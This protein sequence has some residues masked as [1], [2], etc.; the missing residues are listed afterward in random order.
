MEPLE[1]QYNRNRRAIGLSGIEYSFTCKGGAMRTLVLLPLLLALAAPSAAWSGSADTAR[2]VAPRPVSPRL[3]TV[4]QVTALPAAVR[5]TFG[6]G[7]YA[8]PAVLCQTAVTTAEYVNRL[9]PRLL[10]AIS[11]TESGRPDPR[12]GHLRAWPWT[13]NAEGAGIFFETK[14][15]AVAAVKALQARGIRSIDVGCLQVNLMYH[16]D[17]FASL[18]EAFDPRG[19]ANYAARFLNA[20]YAEGNDWVHAVAAY[21]SETPALGD[22]Y[23][24]L[25]MT[26]WQNG[27]PRVPAPAQAAYRDFSGADQ[28]RGDPV[29]G[30][31][32][33]GAFAPSSRVYG[34]FA[35]R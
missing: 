20:L 7:I 2:S 9:P 27:D 13:I 24:V 31:L 23:R 21:H 33:Y 28:G 6:Q 35:P 30:N 11:L 15:Q 19:N 25:V 32:A 22:A 34:A 4:L 10:E 8:D 29:R 16:P 18:E 14:P 17:A 26:R 12:S 1:I 5:P 3:V